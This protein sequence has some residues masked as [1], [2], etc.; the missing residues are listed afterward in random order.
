MAKYMEEFFPLRFDRKKL[1]F[2]RGLSNNELAAY[3]ELPN[4]C[5]DP[6]KVPPRNPYH[7]LT[8][9]W[10]LDET[11]VSA[12]G[13]EGE[14]SKNDDTKLV[15]RPNAL[16]CLTAIRALYQVEFIVW[17]AGIKSHAKRVCHSIGPDLFDHV[18]SRSKYWNMDNKDLNKL[19]KTGRSLNSMILVD[20]RM[21]VGAT[22]PENLLVI[23]EFYPKESGSNDQSMLY[24]AN[25]IFRACRKYLEYGTKRPLRTF[26]HSPLT[27]RLREDRKDYYGVLCFESRQHLHDRMREFYPEEET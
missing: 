10:D 1:E 3:P 2:Q 4:H 26:L 15:I 21:D 27:Q 25:I 16:N 5:P 13:T 18:I 19:A 8:I 14:D 7:L 6:E 23:P 20:N 9:V 11:L 12:D 17:T 24:A 22:H